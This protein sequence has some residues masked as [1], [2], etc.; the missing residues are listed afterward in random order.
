MCTDREQY[1]ADAYK[2]AKEIAAG[3][4]EMELGF[5]KYAIERLAVM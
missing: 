5:D 3:M 1:E 4:C 2:A